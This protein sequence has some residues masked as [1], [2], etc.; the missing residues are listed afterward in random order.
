M[1]LFTIGL[2]ELNPDGTLKQSGGRPIETYTNADVS[3]LARVF[4][5]YDLD[6]TGNT[7]TTEV[8]STRQ[9]PHPD[10]VR[11]PK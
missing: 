11:R 7:Y 9:I 5:G 3:G 1:Q 10:V 2:F 4:T 8:G 6:F